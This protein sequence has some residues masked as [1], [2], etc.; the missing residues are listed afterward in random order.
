M[1]AALL[2]YKLALIKV[3]VH[4]YLSMQIHIIFFPKQ[5]NHV[6]HFHNFNFGLVKNKGVA[7]LRWP[8]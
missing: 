5:I 2:K 1:F 6:F 4:L 3:F 7:T 8:H